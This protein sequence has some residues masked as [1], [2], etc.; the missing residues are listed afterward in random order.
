MPINIRRLL[1]VPL[2]VLVVAACN[3]SADPG[4]ATAD[5]PTSTAPTAG[6]TTPATTGSFSECMAQYGLEVKDPK[7]GEGL[8]I[9]PL[10]SENPK[11]DEAMEAC[12]GFLEGGTRT[13]TSDPADLDKYKAFAKCMRENGLP[14]FPD[15]KPGSDEGMFGAGV[16]RNSPAFQTASQKCNQHLAGVAG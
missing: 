14:D 16:D 3:D 1:V 9:D 5:Q 12:K 8:G 2:F 4:V 13:E 15:P 10:V 7:P 6:A 11:F